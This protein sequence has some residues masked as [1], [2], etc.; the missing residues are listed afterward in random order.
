[1]FE[2]TVV[3]SD[4]FG[5]PSVANSQALKEEQAFRATRHLSKRLLDEVMA[6][7]LRDALVQVVPH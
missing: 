4:G 7:N 5:G 6:P 2:S 3:A 1:L